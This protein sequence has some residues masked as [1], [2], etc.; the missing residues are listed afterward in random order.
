VRAQ[1]GLDAR[2]GCQR[3]DRG[4]LTALPVEIVAREDVAEQ[5]SPQISV[6][7]RREL[8]DWPLNWRARY[9][10]LVGGAN[11]E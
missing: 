11:G 7:D 10:G 5:V 4:E 2:R 1:L 6:D 8:E 3:P 9:L